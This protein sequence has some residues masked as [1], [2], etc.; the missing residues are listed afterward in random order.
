[1]AGSLHYQLKEVQSIAATGSAFAA[2]LADASVLTWG[3]PL[4]G[5]D[6]SEMQEQLRTLEHTVQVKNLPQH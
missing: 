1:M 4:C 5:G 6:S 2:V 3:D